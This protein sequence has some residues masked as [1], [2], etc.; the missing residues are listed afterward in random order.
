MKIIGIIGEG[1][2]GTNL[3]HYISDFP[4]EMRWIVSPA[5]DIEKISKTWSKKVVRGLN[6]G[7]IDPEGAARRN[8]AIITQ[9]LHAVGDCDL[10]IETI[11]ERMDLKL[12]LFKKMD[13]IAPPDCIFASNSSSILPS[14]LSPSE[15]RNPKMIG[16]HF[17]YPASLKNI[18]ELIVHPLTDRL[19]VE[20]SISFLNTIQRKFLTQSEPDAF[21]LNRIFLEVQAEAWHIVREG[22]MSPAQLDQ[23]VR[24]RLFPLGPFECMDVVGMDVML[25]AINNYIRCY[26]NPEHY[27]SLIDELER[28]VSEG[29]LGI[30]SGKGFFDH[31]ESSSEQKTQVSPLQE[32]MAIS[33]MTRLK[34]TLD[35]AINRLGTGVS[36]PRADLLAG[37]KE[38]FGE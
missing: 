26:P 28:L 36:Y 17:F 1:K 30:K 13:P 12:D 10:I 29:R 22:M 34:E 15:G 11:P 5:A 6:A 20:S 8:R 4:F 35:E 9:D 16:L 18:A 19:T 21:I 31:S 23:L 27:E 32:D 33:A 2:M 25:P 38:Y 24:T 7:I 37:L 3:F 14:E